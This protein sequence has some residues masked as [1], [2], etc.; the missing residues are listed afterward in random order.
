MLKSQKMKNGVVIAVYPKISKKQKTD[1]IEHYL[2]TRTNKRKFKLPVNCAQYF[3]NNYVS[4]SSMKE[5][6]DWLKKNGNKLEQEVIP[7]SWIN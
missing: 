2:Q 4:L 7:V 6:I 3:K 1:I 5:V